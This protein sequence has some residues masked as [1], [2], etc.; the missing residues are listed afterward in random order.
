MEKLTVTKKNDQ[1]AMHDLCFKLAAEQIAAG[2]DPL[3]VASVFATQA[4]A[5]Y[6]TLLDDEGYDCVVEHIKNSRHLV[7]RIS[8]VDADQLH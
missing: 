7:P 6:R 2:Y 4:L 5:L 3:E 8:L 1:T